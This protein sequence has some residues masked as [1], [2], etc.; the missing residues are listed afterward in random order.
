MEAFD[1]GM[2]QRD[3]LEDRWRPMIVGAELKALWNGAKWA[4]DPS[5]LDEKGLE[6]R[7]G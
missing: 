1:A 5:E 4:C 7:N 6:G 2:E 3:H